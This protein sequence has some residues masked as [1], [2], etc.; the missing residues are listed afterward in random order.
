MQIQIRT[1][2]KAGRIQDTVRSKLNVRETV[3]VAHR[4]RKD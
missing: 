3:R 2:R 1:E 4:R